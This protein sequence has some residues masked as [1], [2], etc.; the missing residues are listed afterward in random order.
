MRGAREARWD[1][2]RRL[3]M[4]TRPVSGVSIRWFLDGDRNWQLRFPRPVGY[5]GAREIGGDSRPV[6]R[7]AARWLQASTPERQTAPSDRRPDAAMVRLAA[8]ALAQL[9]ASAGAWDEI[10]HLVPLGVAGL[11]S[12]SVWLFRR[13]LSARYRPVP[14][15]YTTTTSVV[16]PAYRE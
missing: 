6:P 12:W 3:S 15:G 5:I 9:A 7:T 8:A 11:V 2:D 13:T 14:A 4:G 16:V 1:I 10:R